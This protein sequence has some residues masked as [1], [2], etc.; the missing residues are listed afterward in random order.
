M[1][2][3]VTLLSV[4][5]QCDYVLMRLRQIKYQVPGRRAFFDAK[6]YQ[7]YVQLGLY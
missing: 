4:I 3:Q 1:C 2:M 7:Y 5:H 6:A